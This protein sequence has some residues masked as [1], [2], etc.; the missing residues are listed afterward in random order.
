MAP[1]GP[2]LFSNHATDLPHL[3]NRTLLRR[4]WC[5]SPDSNRDAGKG[6]GF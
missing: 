6:N 2:G 4:G 1:G 5:L 3:P